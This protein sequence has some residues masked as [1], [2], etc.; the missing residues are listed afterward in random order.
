MSAKS[1]SM[2][3]VIFGV[4]GFGNTFIDTI[5]LVSKH[6]DVFVTINFNISTNIKFR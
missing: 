3:L 2:F 5:L 1:V 6:E 4:I